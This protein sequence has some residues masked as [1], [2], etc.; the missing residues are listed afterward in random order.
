MAVKSAV[1]S[2]Y[3][4]RR[5]AKR[6]VSGSPELVESIEMHLKEGRGDASRYAIAA[7]E[8]LEYFVATTSWMLER[9]IKKLPIDV[10]DLIKH[11][12]IKVATCDSDLL[13]LYVESLSGEAREKYIENLSAEDNVKTADKIDRLCAALT[14]WDFEDVTKDRADS[15]IQLASLDE[16][17]AHVKEGRPDL[18]IN[19][20]LVYLL[21]VYA[22]LTAP[23]VSPV[24]DMNMKSELAKACDAIATSLEELSKTEE[25]PLIQHDKKTASKI[26]LFGVEAFRSLSRE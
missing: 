9:R 15:R 19:D 13:R 7:N 4:L 22:D 26:R 21:S 3:N 23:G 8:S 24:N 18:A 12:M 5:S 16:I 14:S 1:K 20:A 17:K 25:G 11:E 6:V 2:E 10:P